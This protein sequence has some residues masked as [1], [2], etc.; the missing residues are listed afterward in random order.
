MK[1]QKE[2]QQRNRKV[3]AAKGNRSQKM[4]AFRC[5]LDNVEWLEKQP[6]KGR[7]INDLIATDRLKRER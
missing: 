2:E 3:Y 7:Y 4:L 1:Q 5:D 6:N